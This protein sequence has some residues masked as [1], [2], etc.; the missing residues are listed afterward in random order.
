M[1]EFTVGH[2]PNQLI[3][4]KTVNVLPGA[5]EKL[6]RFMAEKRKRGLRVRHAEDKQRGYMVLQARDHHALNTVVRF[7][8]DAGLIR[9]S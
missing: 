6:A 1:T 8:R 2:N 3:A 7:L 5:E 9:R 4:R